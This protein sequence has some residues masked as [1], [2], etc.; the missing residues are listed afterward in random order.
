MQ[1]YDRARKT[2]KQEHWTKYR[3]VRN[4]IKQFLV[5][6]HDDYIK[7]LLDTTVNEKSKRFWSYIKNLRDQVGISPL[8][9]NDTSRTD[10]VGKAEALNHQFQ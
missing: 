3:E 2:Q 6:T 10:Q 8:Q 4:Q 9:Y 7:N 1:L 5:D